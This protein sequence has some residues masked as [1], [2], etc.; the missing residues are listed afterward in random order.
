MEEL[1][2]CCPKCGNKDLQVTTETDIQTTGK[3]YSNAQGCLGYLMFGPLGMLCGSCGKGQKT[4][5]TNTTY[6]VCP[7]CG[8]KFRR[9][10]DIKSEI[11]EYKKRLTIVRVFAV[12]FTIIMIVYATSELKFITGLIIGIIAGLI[13]AGTAELTSYFVTNKLKSELEYIE[14]GMKKFK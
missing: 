3:N 5:S 9:P 11:E 8:E 4:T 12:I 2:L 6:F 13:V 14:N 10:D 1:N 7:K